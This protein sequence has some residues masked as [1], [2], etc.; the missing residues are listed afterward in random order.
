MK[1]NELKVTSIEDLKRSAQGEL[2]ELPGFTEDVPFVVKLKKP[3]LLNLVKTKK[4][5]NSLLSEANKLFVGGVS[6]VANNNPLGDDKTMEQLFD[7][8]DIICEAAF[9]EPT[10]KD[11]KEA[12]ISLTDE[13]ILAVFSYTQT[14]VKSLENFR[15]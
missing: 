8:L 14:G 11:L 12:G 1:N 15:K 2:V 7:L 6:K 4:I 3:S 5:P 9:V 10:I 13:Q